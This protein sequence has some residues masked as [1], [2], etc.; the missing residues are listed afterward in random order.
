MMAAPCYCPVNGFTPYC[1]DSTR[2]P[3]PVKSESVSMPST[4]FFS[5][6]VTSP[7]L[8]RDTV[9]WT[10]VQLWITTFAGAGGF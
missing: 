8:F 2:R 4:A 7:L 1:S 3:G 5:M 10:P 6:M 9:G